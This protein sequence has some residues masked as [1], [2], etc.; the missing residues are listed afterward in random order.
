[1]SELSAADYRDKARAIIDSG[2]YDPDRIFQE[3]VRYYLI[4]D[5]ET[6][7]FYDTQDDMEELFDG[8]SDILGTNFSGQP[9][10][11]AQETEDAKRFRKVR[12][13]VENVHYDSKGLLARNSPADQTNPSHKFDGQM[14]KVMHMIRAAAIAAYVGETIAD[15]ASWGNEVVDM[16]KRPIQQ[17]GKKTKLYSGVVGSGYDQRDLQWGLYGSELQN[18]F[19]LYSD[20][21]AR[22]LAK[23]FANGTFLL[24]RWQDWYDTSGK[25][26]YD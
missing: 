16:G 17:L 25:T 1:M 10:G 18:H 4:N 13:W 23:K 21:K 9:P 7:W 5:P 2:I 12:N 26:L 19:D 15:I 3:L 8:L 11:S 22:S 6:D 24:S 20:K 14:D